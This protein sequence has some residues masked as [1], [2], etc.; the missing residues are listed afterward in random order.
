MGVLHFVQ[1]NISCDDAR[2]GRGEELGEAVA[3]L[4]VVVDLGCGLHR[5]YSVYLR[6]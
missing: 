2:D 4:T 3:G 5:R 1:S 6:Y